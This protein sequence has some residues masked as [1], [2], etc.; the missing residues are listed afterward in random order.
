[1]DAWIQSLRARATSRR[2]STGASGLLLAHPCPS[3]PDAAARFAQAVGAAH[4]DDLVIH[5]PIASLMADRV[6]I[7]LALVRA[8][9]RGIEGLRY[10]HRLRAR[11]PAGHSP[12]TWLRN[13]VGM[14]HEGAVCVSEA[15]LSGDFD[16]IATLTSHESRE[17]ADESDLI[18]MRSFYPLREAEA[19][20]LLQLVF[21]EPEPD[22]VR[23]IVLS[24]AEEILGGP[25]PHAPAFR[26]GLRIWLQD[27]LRMPRTVVVF[28]SWTPTRPAIHLIDAALDREV[29]TLPGPPVPTLA[30]LPPLEPRHLAAGV[31][32]LTAAPLN[33][34]DEAPLWSG[35]Q[36]RG[37]VILAWPDQSEDPARWIPKHITSA[38]E[39]WAGGTC[40]VLVP[41]WALGEVH[42]N[43]RA[44]LRTARVRWVPVSLAE[45][46][47]LNALGAMME[48]GPDLRP[49]LDR[50]SLRIQ[51]A[52]SLARM[53]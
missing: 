2:F 53:R 3:E 45:S 14:P 9:F 33:R 28:H 12:L 17:S 18:H 41:R 48:I 31:S 43:S 37:V 42:A 13:T 39:T 50:L 24:D 35:A 38:L 6:T 46:V 36:D 10:L 22:R 40:A 21:E 47:A 49:L 25:A 11:I 52:W 32:L 34:R 1:M 29:H 15:I 4:P 8:L 20:V 7:G 51:Q 19:R 16:A 23:W 26:A 44:A 5:L 30:E 27:F